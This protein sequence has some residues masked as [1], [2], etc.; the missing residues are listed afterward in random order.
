MV[1]NPVNATNVLYTFH[2]YAASHPS[3]YLNALS[4]AADK[5]PMF[6][7]EFGTQTYTGDGA[8]DFTILL[9]V[10]IPLSLP[11]LAVITPFFSRA[12]DSEAIL[13]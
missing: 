4:R 2:F 10:V 8:N 9:R 6:V 13:L 12:A 1:N 7:T 11:A 3:E 5:I